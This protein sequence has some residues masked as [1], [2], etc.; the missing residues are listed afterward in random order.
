MIPSCLYFDIDSQWRTC[1]LL[2]GASENTVECDTVQRVNV[3]KGCDERHHVVSMRP[4]DVNKMLLSVFSAVAVI[5]VNLIYL[6][7]HFGL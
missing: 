7:I 4:M 3:C 2:P 1:M 5:K 6:Y